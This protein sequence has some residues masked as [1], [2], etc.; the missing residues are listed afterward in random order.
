MSKINS[1]DIDSLSIDFLNKLK[2]YKEDYKKSSVFKDI[3]KII[4]GADFKF[5]N[6]YY[7]KLSKEE[8]YSFLNQ[9][10]QNRHKKI[11]DTLEEDEFQ[12]LIDE[13]GF[14]NLNFPFYKD[15][16]GIERIHQNLTIYNLRYLLDYYKYQTL[17][18]LTKINK[19]EGKYYAHDYEINHNFLIFFERMFLTVGPEIK[20]TLAFYDKEDFIDFVNFTKINKNNIDIYI[21]NLSNFYLEY[22][23]QKIQNEHNMLQKHEFVEEFEKKY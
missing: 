3:F 19:E 21:Q 14:E 5:D 6:I 22:F 20:N 12:K 23:F 1:K 2:K 18:F 15:K 16:N 13:L 8:L 7:K 10:V 11:K 9:S 17:D 4:L